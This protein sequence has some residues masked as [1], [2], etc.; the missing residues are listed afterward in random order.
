MRKV[1][2]IVISFLGQ[3]PSQNDTRYYGGVEID[4]LV[5]AEV[6][7]G[8]HPVDYPYGKIYQWGRSEGVGYGSESDEGVFYVINEY[9]YDW[10]SSDE[11]VVW[12]ADKDPCPDEWRLPTSEE[13]TSL[14]ANYSDFQL[15]KGQRGRWFYGSERGDLSEAIFLPAAGARYY[16]GFPL[17]RTW[18]GN[19]WASDTCNKCGIHLN[20]MS[21]N[22]EMARDY[23]TMGFSVRCVRKK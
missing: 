4:G 11:G 18:Y 23:K 15:Y 13:L 22:V 19:Y 9:P 7:C 8:Y 20:F 17:N 1:L 6:N 12:N 5:W 2:F 14:M 16:D 3:L 21:G 10:D